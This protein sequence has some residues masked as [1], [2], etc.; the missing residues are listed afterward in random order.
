MLNISN[1]IL[2]SGD[3]EIRIV[4][5]PRDTIRI[6]FANGLT[7]LDDGW[8]AVTETRSMVPSCRKKMAG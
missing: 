2:N 3:T 1:K 8:E 6:A 7:G 5:L 4:G